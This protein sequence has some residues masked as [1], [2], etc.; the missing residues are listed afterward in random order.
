MSVR[1]ESFAT[2]IAATGETAKFEN[3]NALVSQQ[4]MP[5]PVIICGPKKPLDRGDP[6]G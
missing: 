3:E 4:L 1:D 6:V 2:V 5:F